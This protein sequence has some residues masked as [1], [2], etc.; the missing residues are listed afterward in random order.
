[1][2]IG[3]S[4]YLAG[5]SRLNDLQD[6]SAT[7]ISSHLQN[8]VAFSSQLFS[9]HFKTI[10]FNVSASLLGLASQA[11]L[12]LPSVMLLVLVLLSLSAC[13]AKHRGHLHGMKLF[14]FLLSWSGLI[15]PLSLDILFA[16]KTTF[17][18]LRMMYLGSLPMDF[19]ILFFNRS[20]LWMSFIVL[21]PSL[22]WLVSMLYTGREIRSNFTRTFHPPFSSLCPSLL[23]LSLAS[24]SARH[25]VLGIIVKIL[26]EIGFV[27]PK[28]MRRNIQ[29]IEGLSFIWQV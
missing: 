25:I 21:S 10:D 17:R 18:P 16:Q 20:F 6:Y 28:T 2:T 22:F 26:S 23:D 27:S 14:L 11:L 4:M 12:L 29:S 19:F 1:M 13:L 24:W 9:L 7:L 3:V 8:L 15:H 5:S